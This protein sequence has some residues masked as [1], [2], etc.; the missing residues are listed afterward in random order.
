MPLYPFFK[1]WVLENRT[2]VL[3]LTQQALY[4]LGHTQPFY[5]FNVWFAKNKLE[6]FRNISH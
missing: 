1:M 6:T 5:V 3:M 4:L 2:Q